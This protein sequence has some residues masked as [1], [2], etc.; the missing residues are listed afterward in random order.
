[1]VDDEWLLWR[2]IAGGV[3]S[4]TEANG[5]YEDELAKVNI[6]M[7]KWMEVSE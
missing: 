5:M 1:M 3:L 7:N 6:A 2:P 4:Y